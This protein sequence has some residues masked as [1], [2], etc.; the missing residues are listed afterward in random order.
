MHSPVTFRGCPEA[1]L[2]VSGEPHHSKNRWLNFTHHQQSST[3]PFLKEL[4]DREWDGRKPQLWMRQPGQQSEERAGLRQ[5]GQQCCLQIL[6]LP[7]TGP[8]GSM[9]SDT[10]LSP[11]PRSCPPSYSVSHLLSLK[12]KNSSFPKSSSDSNAFNRE[13]WATCMPTLIQ[14]LH[15][16]EFIRCIYTSS[17]RHTLINRT[18]GHLS[19]GTDIQYISRTVLL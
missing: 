19:P 4:S 11:T 5:P 10:V 15:Y 6:P 14:K 7:A 8:C 12:K 1:V 13:F 17:P 2:P 9:L 18:D 3:H 16:Q